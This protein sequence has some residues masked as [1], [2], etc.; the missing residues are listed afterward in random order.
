LLDVEKKV[1][2]ELT[3]SY[4]MFPGS[5]VSGLFFLSES[6]RDFEMGK[7]GRD[8]LGADAGRKGMSL[9]DAEKWLVPNLEG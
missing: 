7:I 6:A 3:S 8:Q 9:A 4:G 2:M 5:N 1:G